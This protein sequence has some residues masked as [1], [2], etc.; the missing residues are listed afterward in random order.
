MLETSHRFEIS[1]EKKK[2]EIHFLFSPQ[3]VMDKS[4]NLETLSRSFFFFENSA[5]DTTMMNVQFSIYY[6]YIYKFMAYS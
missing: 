1:N 3:N 5:W 4:C 6:I 2:R